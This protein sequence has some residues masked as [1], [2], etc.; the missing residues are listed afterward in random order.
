MRIQV[1]TEVFS[2]QQQEIDDLK[3][4]VAR[5]M[6]VEEDVC[7]MKNHLLSFSMNPNECALSNLR[8]NLVALGANA[9]PAI[10]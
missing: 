6:R 10:G 9:D 8:I 1:T 2:R 3:R 5:L 4:E 7:L